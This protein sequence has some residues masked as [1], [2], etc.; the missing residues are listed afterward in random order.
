MAVGG[1]TTVKQ[2]FV[3]EGVMTQISR[4]NALMDLQGVAVGAQG[5]RLGQSNVPFSCYVSAHQIHMLASLKSDRIK[6]L[7]LLF[8]TL[9]T[10]SH[11]FVCN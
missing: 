6:I 1:V 2:C 7:Y 4:F 8:C 10:N 9:F 3:E 11:D 5:L